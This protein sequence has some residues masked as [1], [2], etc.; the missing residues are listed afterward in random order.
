MT[1]FQ[2][3]RSVVL[4]VPSASGSDALKE[5]LLLAAGQLPLAEA[6]AKRT[7]ILQRSRRGRLLLRIERAERIAT[8]AFASEDE[9][10]PSNDTDAGGQR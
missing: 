4:N 6:R 5:R 10:E 3:A 9:S 7:E 8:D 1:A 2:N